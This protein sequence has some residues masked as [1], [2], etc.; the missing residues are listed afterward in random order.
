MEVLVAALKEGAMKPA[1]ETERETPET[2]VALVLGTLPPVAVVLAAVA[3]EA[4][5]AVLAVEGKLLKLLEDV[6][7]EKL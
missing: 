6:L 7:L 3:L 2:V 1:V 4:V 5:V